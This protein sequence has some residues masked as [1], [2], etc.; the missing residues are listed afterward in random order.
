MLTGRCRSFG[1]LA[2]GA[3]RVPKMGPADPGFG[4]DLGDLQSGDLRRSHAGDGVEP[5]VCANSLSRALGPGR[6]F[7]VA[8]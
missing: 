7:H 4:V 8:R 6:E 5:V 2:L 3:V 1:A